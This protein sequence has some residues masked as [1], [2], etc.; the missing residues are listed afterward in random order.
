MAK[1]SWYTKLLELIKKLLNIGGTEEPE[2]DPNVL[3]PIKIP[4]GSKSTLSGGIKGGEIG[5][6]DGVQLR[7]LDI[8]TDCFVTNAAVSAK[9]VR[10][11]NGM[12][13]ADDWINS[14]GQVMVFQ[15]WT[16]GTSEKSAMSTSNPVSIKS[17]SRGWYNSCNKNS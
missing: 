1:S 2:E 17:D 12:M 7:F 8:D 6:V 9:A 4:H 5:Y 10:I 15:Y 16:L 3:K 11:K 13:V 14:A